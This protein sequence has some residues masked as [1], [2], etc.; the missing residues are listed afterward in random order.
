[1]ALLVQDLDELCLKVLAVVVPRAARDGP[2]GLE[3]VQHVDDLAR[4]V[5]AL[6]LLH[7]SLLLQRLEHL[8][9]GGLRQVGLDPDVP[10]PRAH[11]AGVL[12]DLVDQLF[13]GVALD[14]EKLTKNSNI[15]MSD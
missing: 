1:M 11:V 12:D 2:V 8:G 14:E 6:D 9:E 13:L 3:V 10:D 15:R 5:D 7:E 4:R